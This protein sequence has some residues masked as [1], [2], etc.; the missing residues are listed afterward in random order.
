M[1][2]QEREEP[3]F[4]WHPDDCDWPGCGPYPGRRSLFYQLADRDRHSTDDDGVNLC[5]PAEYGSG[6]LNFGQTFEGTITSRYLLR[7][8]LDAPFMR[9]KSWW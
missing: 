9:S 3:W 1:Q 8:W 7:W 5:R 2:Y 4:A 6:A